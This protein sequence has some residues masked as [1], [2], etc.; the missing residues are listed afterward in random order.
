[1]IHHPPYSLDLAPVDFFLFPR[2]KSELACL[3]MA[4]ESFQKSWEGVARTIPQDDFTAAFR[5]WTEQSK[6]CVR[7]GSNHV[8]K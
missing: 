8:E 1:M 3:S 2:V 5:Q 4:Q 6:K 7:I